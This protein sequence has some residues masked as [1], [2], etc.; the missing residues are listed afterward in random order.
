MS[1]A[2]ISTRLRLFIQK[3]NGALLLHLKLAS[4][5]STQ[6]VSEL[7][8]KLLVAQLMRG[9]L[10][11]DLP[12]SKEKLTEAIQ[13]LSQSDADLPV[14]KITLTRFFYSRMVKQIEKHQRLFPGFL[15]K[16]QSLD[17]K[18][19][20]DSEWQELYFTYLLKISKNNYNPAYD[21][22]MELILK[23]MQEISFILKNTD[24]STYS[25]KISTIRS[26]LNSFF[27]VFMPDDFKP[28]LLRQFISKAFG[29]LIFSALRRNSGSQLR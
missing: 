13:A 2:I 5:N 28:E 22:M 14:P 23:N 8:L 1:P 18:N 26:I 10:P 24:E 12:A 25:C 21:D 4:K 27:V 20:F 15:P 6:N 9:D 29:M 16:E 7:E 11:F 19:F 3:E 17:L